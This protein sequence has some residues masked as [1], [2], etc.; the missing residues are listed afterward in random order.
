VEA[1][2]IQQVV[3]K[4]ARRREVRG[5]GRPPRDRR[6]P[7]KSHAINQEHRED[8]QPEALTDRQP[9]DLNR[10]SAYGETT[11]QIQAR[12]R[13]SQGSPELEIDPRLALLGRIVRHRGFPKRRPLRRVQAPAADPLLRRGGRAVEAIATRKRT[14][15]RINAKPSGNPVIELVVMAPGHVALGAVVP[16]AR[17]AVLDSGDGVAGDG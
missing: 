5:N 14:M 17:G 1:R 7:E 10:V 2:R 6:S 15:M 12:I 9:R 3:K 16:D 8:R 4:T 11:T 13:T